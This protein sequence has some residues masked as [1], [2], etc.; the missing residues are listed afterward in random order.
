MSDRTL[1]NLLRQIIRYIPGGFLPAI[2]GLMASTFFTKLLSTED[3]GQYSLVISLTGLLT[4]SSSRWLEQGTGR[5]LPEAVTEPEVIRHK[6]ALGQGLLYILIVNLLGTIVI[7]GLFNFTGLK[8][9]TGLL[10]PAA[11][12]TVSGAIYAPLLMV[13]H[14]EMRA[15]RY[16]FYQFGQSF[17]RLI[18]CLLFLNYVNVSAGSLVWGTALSYIVVLPF[19]WKDARVPWI[20]DHSRI[21]V[22]LKKYFVFGMP[23]V[24]WFL[25]ANLLSVGDRWV[26]SIFRGASDV[27]I[28]SA[29]YTL[30]SAAAGLA[31]A[32]VLLAIHPFLMRAWAAG[33]KDEAARWLGKLVEWFCLLSVFCIGLSYLF[34]ADIAR[35]F[36]GPDFRS[37]HSVMSIVLAGALAWQLGMYAQKPLEF[38]EQ[39]RLMLYLAISAAALSL[40]L[41]L[42]LVPLWGY[43]AAALTTFLS[44]GYYAVGAIHF[45]RRNLRWAIPNLQLSVEV[46]VITIV[47]IIAS[48]TIRGKAEGFL[49]Y[50]NGLVLCAGLACLTAVLAATRYVRGL[51][52]SSA[53][54]RT[55]QP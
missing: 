21:P 31:G 10:W 41:N 36:L 5:F 54:E 17:T 34:S 1:S 28:Y 35:L 45:G 20:R 30:I 24:G 29:N 11:L 50:R 7:G 18:L 4:A 32:P 16:S 55:L 48:A 2:I 26:I 33:E 13:L 46:C 6:R 51:R 15:N 22:D 40:L 38:F 9:H 14:V 27:G 47:G 49:G 8:A 39:T 42:V 19:V 23:L 44:R 25:A 53:V 3:F 37:G 52:S 43:P 12:L